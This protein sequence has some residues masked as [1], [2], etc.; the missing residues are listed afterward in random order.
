MAAAAA[1]L[2]GQTAL[3]LRL[4]KHLAPSPA[5]DGSAANVNFSP[6]SV[7]AALSLVAAG[8]ERGA[9]L[10][11]LLAFL[12]APSVAALSFIGSRVS[13]HV[14]ADG[15]YFDGGARVLFVGGVWVDASSG[16]IADAFRGV[17]AESYEAHQVQTVNVTYEPEAA[18]KIINECV[19]KAT[20]VD[21]IIFASDVV[22]T[23][24]DLVLA[25]AVCFSGAWLHS[26]HPRGTWPGTFHRLDGSHGEA[27]FMTAFD[28]MH[29]ACVD[30]FKVLKLPYRGGRMLKVKAVRV[31]RGC[32]TCYSMFVFL[33]DTRDGIA[34]TVDAVTTAPASLQGILAQMTE[35]T[36]HVKLPKFE[37]SFNWDG[38]ER[39]LRR[40][41]LSVPFSPEEADLQGMC[42]GDC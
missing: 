32:E 39:D 13:D 17:A 6:V 37:I 15:S 20:G 23:A 14:L 34:A 4:A 16:G 1:A 31:V 26:F 38:L 25:S 21:G 2:D 24:T 42:V 12:G 11:Q 18:V 35:R 10:D 9:T 30:G 3:A 41:G 5:D 28:A 22:G 8:A 27:N 19:K 7:H 40:L 33:P 36:V 29:V